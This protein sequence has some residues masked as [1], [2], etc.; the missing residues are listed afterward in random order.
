MWIHAV[1]FG[2]NLIDVF[3]AKELEWNSSE[4]NFILTCS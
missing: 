4:K 1:M 3:V 2:W